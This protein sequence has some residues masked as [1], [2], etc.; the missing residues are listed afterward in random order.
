M[1]G[2]TDHNQGRINHSGAHTNGVMAVTLR[3]F[4]PVVYH[5]YTILNVETSKQRGKNLK[6]WQL[7]GEGGVG[8]GAPMVQPALIITDEL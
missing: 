2:S 8:R 5:G 1:R 3:Y 6:I 4:G 7:I